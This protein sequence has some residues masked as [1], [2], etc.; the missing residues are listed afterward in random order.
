[1]AKECTHRNGTY[2]CTL[3]SNHD[4]S[5]MSRTWDRKRQLWLYGRWTDDY[6]TMSFRTK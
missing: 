2:A 5:H 1:M 6:G 4:G 3:D